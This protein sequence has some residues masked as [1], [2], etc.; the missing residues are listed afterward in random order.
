MPTWADSIQRLI[1]RPDLTPYLLHF[2]RTAEQHTGFT[3]LKRILQEGRIKASN[4]FIIGEDKV[5]C[6]MDVPI[7]ALKYILRKD[8][9]FSP[10]G[11]AIT[12]AYAYKKGVRPVLYLSRSE[13]EQL[14]IPNSEQWRVVRFEYRV[15]R[16]RPQDSQRV[17]DWMHEREWRY[18][19]DFVL[20]N[21]PLIFVLKYQEINRLTRALGENS[22]IKP[23][24]IIP[25]L[26]ILNAS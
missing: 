25:L 21:N 10:Y 12:K 7:P 24:A 18:K 3:S 17:A 6:F 8:N 11:I 9:G 4:R 19:G 14:K 22:R 13:I 2:T 26:P 23:R 15:N 5:V 20:P 16:D 1:V